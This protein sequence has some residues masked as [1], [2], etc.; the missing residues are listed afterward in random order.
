MV[1]HTLSYSKF[2]ITSTLS[3]QSLTLLEVVRFLVCKLYQCV[4]FMDVR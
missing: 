4:Y 1:L 3:H 2:P